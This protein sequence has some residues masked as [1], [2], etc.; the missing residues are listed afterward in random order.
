LTADLLVSN[1]GDWPNAHEMALRPVMLRTLGGREQP[2]E[3]L[4]G[5]RICAAAGIAHPQRFFDTLQ[6]L[7]AELVEMRELSDHASAAELRRA[8]E[9]AAGCPWLI[10]EKDAMK[11]PRTDSG[12]VHV[13]EV[14]AQLS[15][16]FW[17]ALQNAL[18]ARGLSPRAM[19]HGSP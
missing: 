8:L 7:G 19:T 17:E 11:L 3:W 1:R 14:S 5:R 12:D 2:L 16:R 4:R 6:N 13:L 18:Q 10:T 15:S 9:Q